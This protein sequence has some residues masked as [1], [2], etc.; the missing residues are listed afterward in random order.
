MSLRQLVGHRR[1]VNS[2]RQNPLC[3]TLTP[4]GTQR[5][6]LSSSAS[7]HEAACTKNWAS[8]ADQYLRGDGDSNTDGTTGFLTHE[9]EQTITAEC[10]LFPK[11]VEKMNALSVISATRA[12]PEAVGPKT[13]Q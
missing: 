4:R 3:L 7:V 8:P 11:S 10:P 2:F 13:D 9:E 1:S 12:N 5:H 6:T